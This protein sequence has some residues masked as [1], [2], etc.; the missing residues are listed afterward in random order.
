[1]KTISEIAGQYEV[2]PTQVKQWKKQLQAGGVDVFNEKGI[3]APQTQTAVEATLYE[4]IGRLKMELD[5][6]KKKLLEPVDVRQAM[7]EPSHPYLS[8][9]QQCDLLELNRST[10][11]YVAATESPLNL[12]LM[13]LMDEQ[14]MRHHSMA[15]HV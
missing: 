4:Q 9:R 6:L 12:E 1:M 13:R 2:H 7:I 11:Y 10:Y 8:V 15:G 3:K 5:W 14:Y